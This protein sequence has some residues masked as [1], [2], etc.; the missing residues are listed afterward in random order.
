MLF[1]DSDYLEKPPTAHP[2]DRAKANPRMTAVN[3]IDVSSARHA[4]VNVV[5]A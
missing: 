1:D 3:H 5:R 2:R 4:S